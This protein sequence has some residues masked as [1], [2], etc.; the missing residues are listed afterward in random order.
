MDQEWLRLND[1]DHWNVPWKK[2]G[3]YLSDRQWGTARE[4]EGSAWHHPTYEQARQQAYRTGEDGIA[5]ISDDRQQLCFAV[6]LWNGVDPYL[7]ERLFGLTPQEGNHG[8]DV[9]EL[10][11]Y[12]DATPTHSYLKFLYK[13]PHA[14]YPY[15]DLTGK[16]RSPQE[17]EYELLETGAFGDGYFDVYVEYA[18]QSPEDI[19]IQLSVCN[20]GSDTAKVH[21]LPSLWFRNTWSGGTQTPKPLLKWMGERDGMSVVSVRHPE[22]GMR[23]LYCEGASVLLFTENEAA[24]EGQP[25]GYSKTGI[26]DYMVQGKTEAV[27][28]QRMGTKLAVHYQMVLEPGETRL[29]RLRLNEVPPLWLR[30][31][32]AHTDGNPFGDFEP[33]MNTRRW[34]AEA[35]YGT[36]TP[37]SISADAR[38]VMRQALA[39]LVWNKQFAATGTTSRKPGLGQANSSI[40][41]MADKWEYPRYDT[42]SPLFYTLPLAIVDLKFAKQQIGLM[43]QST[44]MHPS[45]QLPTE[46]GKF[47]TANP[48]AHAWAVKELYEFERDRYGRS[49]LS[50]L[51]YAFHRLLLNY[52][53]WL[54]R[55][56]SQGKTLLEGGFLG[57]DGL[58]SF[59]AAVEQSNGVVWMAFFC[60]QMLVIALELSLND[61]VYQ[62]L[63]CKFYED[64]LW[65]AEAIDRLGVLENGL[66]YDQIRHGGE[67]QSLRLR[68]FVSLLP[69]CACTIITPDMLDRL[70][71]F[72]ELVN[73][74][75][76]ERPDLI[77]KFA[78]GGVAG[79]AG[80]RVLSLLNQTQLQGTLSSLLSDSEFLSP[81]GI[82]SLSRAHTAPVEVTLGGHT[83]RIAYEPGESTTGS[84]A[85]WRGAVWLPQ[86]FLLIR[87]LTAQH[88]YYGDDLQIAGQNLWQS[89]QE[90]A[91][92][93]VQIF[94]RQEATRP[95]YG[96]LSQFLPADQQ[97]SFWQ[98]NLL[99]HEYFDAETGAGL[100]ASHYGPTG[101]IAWLI[102]F[103]GYRS[104]EQW[105]S[106]REL[107]AS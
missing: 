53:W 58:G 17:P 49:D 48:P 20:R 75:D 89:A 93:L 52:N 80:R 54:N 96:K 28:P 8:E 62:D 90:I 44:Y 15:T 101:L 81:Y 46:E 40:V 51:K 55:Q 99:F 102:Q 47:G 87:A 38:A 79:F 72:R 84:N 78:N 18:K 95:L 41:A 29:V 98:N 6:A 69:L 73:S 34:E 35:F 5:G 24:T 45:G 82:R 74:F 97:D 37:G 57:I 77:E 104:G 61:P 100:G 67:S 7:K 2:W 91:R 56:D 68:S 12:E 63:A 50:F 83:Y 65:L 22:L 26:S 92:R 31:V 76:Q 4:G 16:S 107:A 14:A 19:L 25:G 39:G 36:V 66:F 59:D 1:A 21:I 60:S 103:Y 86:N 70:S 3:P 32:F 27:N 85:N 71:V 106:T 105:R 43:L 88:A 13:Y 33:I 64:F 30:Q 42:W 10:Y 11:F 94:L 23:Y 9:K